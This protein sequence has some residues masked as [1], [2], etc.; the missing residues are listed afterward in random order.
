VE[1]MQEGYITVSDSG[2]ILFCNKNFA[3]M[4]NL[5]PE[6]VIG[7]FL[8]DLVAD[9]DSQMVKHLLEQDYFKAEIRFRNASCSVLPTLVSAKSVTNDRQKFTCLVITDLS[10]QKRTERLNHLV[11]EQSTDA[12]IVGDCTGKIIRANAAAFAL[13]GCQILHQNFDSAVQL[14]AADGSGLYLAHLLTAR[15][16]KI[17]AVGQ[18]AEPELHLLVSAGG[19][20]TEDQLETLGYVITLS[21]ISDSHRLAREMERLDRL[22][23][24]GEMAA[25]IGH[26]VRNP[27]TTVRGYLQ[28]FSQKS[29]FADY[30]D[31]LGVM[32]NELDRANE[33][34]SEFLS[35]AKNKMM[36]LELVSLNSVVESLYPLLQADAFC[37]GN[38]LEL[39]LQDIPQVTADEKEIRQCLL[40]LVRNGLDA[41]PSGGKIL[42]QT[43]AEDEAI[44]LSV[45]DTGPGIPPEILAKLGTPF[46]TTKEN[47]TGLGLPVCFSIAERHHAALEVDTG[48]KGTTFSLVFPLTM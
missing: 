39:A 27:M 25:G 9:C 22:S 45:T 20:S 26:E 8:Y 12:I 3:T 4:I 32:I 40:N 36:Q 5:P 14:R 43:S 18:T 42:I 21:D 2:I 23:L 7:A 17:Q 37:R 28:M 48:I 6:K 31:T 47:G 11:L 24:V 30:R 35:L 29:A 44:R 19:L 16:G 34:I 33:I 46:L 41:M 1:E 10:M 13:F 15:S 38:D